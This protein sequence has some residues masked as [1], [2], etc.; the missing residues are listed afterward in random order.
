MPVLWVCTVLFWKLG[1]FCSCPILVGACP[2]INLPRYFIFIFLFTVLITASSL[3]LRPS[4]KPPRIQYWP[5]L[6]FAHQAIHVFCHIYLGFLNTNISPA[7]Q[8]P[9]L[10][11]GAE[12]AQV[13]P[14]KKPL[15]PYCN[16]PEELFLPTTLRW[17]LCIPLIIIHNP[18]SQ[19][20]CQIRTL[21]LLP[22]PCFYLKRSKAIYRK[23]NIVTNRLQVHL[24]LTA[25]CMVDD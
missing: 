17:H 18:S 24:G 4:L 3:F 20:P 19:A 25:M 10:H 14:L 22:F 5:S 2:V 9:F 8:A 15:F 12:N 1:H 11:S 6:A 21:C 23:M 13:R 7:W 16:A